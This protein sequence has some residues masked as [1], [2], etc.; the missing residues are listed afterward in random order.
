[1]CQECAD[2]LVNAQHQLLEFQKEEIASLETF[3]AQL[4]SLPL[5]SN[6]VD[7]ASASS[8]EVF[9]ASPES[10]QELQ[11]ASSDLVS[12]GLEQSSH[13]N[14]NSPQASS[15]PCISLN[16]ETSDALAGGTNRPVPTFRCS[17]DGNSVT[18]NEDFDAATNSQLTKVHEELLSLQRE[19]SSLQQESRILDKQIAMDTK[20]LQRRQEELDRINNE[21]NEKRLMLFEVE[22]ALAVLEARFEDARYQYDRLRQTNVL[23]AAFPIWY[24]GHI[25]IING[26]HLG[27]L[28]N[29]PIGWPEINGAL[30]QCAMLVTCLA[31]KLS[32]AFRNCVIIPMGNQSKIAALPNGSP[33]P[34]YNSTSAVW[35]FTS[36]R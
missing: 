10:G 27:R 15:E 26:L 16:V 17:T 18:G 30:G 21:Y 9:S 2:V 29:K 22:E 31:K 4:K 35:K 13:S 14:H 23:N 25:G 8:D 1:M 11:Q 32:H 5:G 7:E 19:L 33:L 12:P 36:S 28:P 3:L 34:L 24:D 20:E 6:E